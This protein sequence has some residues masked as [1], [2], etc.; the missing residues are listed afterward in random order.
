MART[1][2]DTR[3]VGKVPRTELEAKANGQGVLA[4]QRK[5][6]VAPR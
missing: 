1:A 5:A 4:S 2:Y 6:L 3:D